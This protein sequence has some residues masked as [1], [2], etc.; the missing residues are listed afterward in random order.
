MHAL[1][2]GI[3]KRDFINEQA[4]SIAFKSSDYGWL[5]GSV[6]V[7]T[8]TYAHHE[9][10]RERVHRSEKTRKLF[11][12]FTFW[13]FPKVLTSPVVEC[14]YHLFPRIQI[15]FGII[16]ANQDMTRTG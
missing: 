16:L 13:G 7:H 8:H 12:V 2:G 4:Y 15:S 3:V 11:F 14:I 6:S 1:A 9:T 5:N 10:T